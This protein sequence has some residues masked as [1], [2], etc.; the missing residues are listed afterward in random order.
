RR[1]GERWVVEARSG[2]SDADLTPVPVIVDTAGNQVTVRYNTSFA[3]RATLT[4]HSDGSLHGIYRFA[5]EAKDRALSFTRVTTATAT[6]AEAAPPAPLGVAFRQS[7]AQATVGEEGADV[8]A[9]GW[10]GRGG[11]AGELAED[12]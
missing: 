9:V 1:D 7:S 10:V 8:A 4:L 5:F 3:S 12:G 6:A 11:G 2:V